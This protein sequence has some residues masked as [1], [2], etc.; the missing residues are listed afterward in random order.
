ML[1]FK[2]LKVKIGT[3]EKVVTLKSDLSHSWFG[4]CMNIGSESVGRIFDANGESIDS[5]DFGTI[6]EEIS[7]EEYYLNSGPVDLTNIRLY[8]FESPITDESSMK[9]DLFRTF[10]TNANNAII[11]DKAEIPN[12]MDY[13]GQIR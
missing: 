7:I 6:N 10:T 1:G 12:Y 4:L 13:L 11:T 3:F 5:F 2:N 8:E 9:E